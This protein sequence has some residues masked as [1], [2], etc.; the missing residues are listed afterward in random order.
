MEAALDV[1]ATRFSGDKDGLYWVLRAKSA[2]AAGASPIHLARLLEGVPADLGG[3]VRQRL[4]QTAAYWDNIR[5]ASLDRVT[6]LWGTVVNA[7]RVDASS[8]M[9]TE[10]QKEVF[11]FPTDSLVALF[12]A[13]RDRMEIADQLHH[14]FKPMPAPECQALAALFNVHVDAT[15][16]ADLMQRLVRLLDAEGPLSE[17]ESA[18]LATLSNTSLVHAT[19]RGKRGD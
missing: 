17:S 12:R 19:F 5:Y 3:E 13:A 10:A 4:E 8:P 11:A 7:L 6:Q 18:D 9:A 15:L 1:W 2:E 14:A 16:D